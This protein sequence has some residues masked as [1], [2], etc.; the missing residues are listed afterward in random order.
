MTEQLQKL[1]VEKYRPN[2]LEDY[3]FQNT[4]QKLSFAKMI[5]DKSIPH[6]LLSGVQGT[7]KTT[8]AMLLINELELDDTDVLIINASDENNVD[9]IRDKLKSFVATFALGPFKVVLLEEADYITPQGQAVLR[10]LM[11]EYT[12]S[13]R[14]I[15][16]CNYEHKIVPAIQSRCQHYRFKSFD[17]DDIAERVVNILATEHVKFSL[18]M[19]DKYVAAGYPDVRKIIQLLQQNSIDGVLSEPT[20]DG[21]VGDYKFELLDLIERDSW[22]EIRKMLCGQVA[23]EEWEDV[24]RFL[25]ENMHKSAKFSNQ[26]KWEAGIVIVADHLYKHGIVADPEINAAAMFIR[27]TQV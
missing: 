1:W 13:A 24:Y 18:E 22:F 8:M 23:A 21:E 4:N 19:I 20:S 16:T 17:K 9:T 25:Y 12:D 14:F 7:G 27:L 26:D 6:L 5:A 11:E 10:R 15:L 3:I 2:H